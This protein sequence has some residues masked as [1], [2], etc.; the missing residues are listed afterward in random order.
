[1]SEE[2]RQVLQMVQNGVITP[3]EAAQLLDALNAPPPAR[4]TEPVFYEAPPD[5]KHLRRHWEVPFFVGLILLGVAG[6]CVSNVSNTL[7]L[8]CGW[9]LFALAGMI[10]VIGW[11]SQWSPWVHVRIR[12][13][14]GS[15]IAISLPLPLSLI[16]ELV[17]LSR[18]LVRRFT[19]AETVENLDTAATL[20]TAF[21]GAPLDEPI[22]V[23]VDEPDGD[24][25]RVYI[26]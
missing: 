3:E 6:L 7:L 18:P 23:E 5:M 11:L 1:M 12:E 2:Q 14:D 25:V 24:H 19:D 10:T 17:E 4:V 16:D 22:T 20:L 21:K 15:R 9:S 26:G 8:I 13:R